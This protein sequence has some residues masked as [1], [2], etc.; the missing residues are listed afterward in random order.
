[1]AGLTPASPCDNVLLEWLCALELRARGSLDRDGIV[2][3]LVGGPGP[4]T[5]PDFPGPAVIAACPDT[6]H[7]PTV[8][9]ARAHLPPTSGSGAYHVLDSGLGVRAVV[10][11]ITEPLGHAVTLAAGPRPPPGWRGCCAIAA[12]ATDLSYLKTHPY[13][14]CHHSPGPCV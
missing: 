9:V 6:E 7:G 10:Q 5:M 13:V 14:N 12:L 2:P 3:L 11:R 4:D 8:A 1:M